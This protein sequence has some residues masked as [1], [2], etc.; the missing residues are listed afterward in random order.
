MQQWDGERRECK[1]ETV[2]IPFQQIAWSNAIYYLYIYF[3][4]SGCKHCFLCIHR[5]YLHTVDGLSNVMHSWFGENAFSIDRK[6]LQNVRNFMQCMRQAPTCLD[7]PDQ[8]FSTVLI[9]PNKIVMKQFPSDSEFLL[10]NFTFFVQFFLPVSI[11]KPKSFCYWNFRISAA[12][13]HTLYMY[14]YR[15]TFSRMFYRGFLCKEY[16]LSRESRVENREDTRVEKKM[17]WIPSL[18]FGSWIS[19]QY[20][21]WNR[22]HY[23]S[24]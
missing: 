2:N 20:F 10:R 16:C 18:N 23:H 11:L 9:N 3:C 21:R 14:C 8:S 1:N 7:R 15:G 12:G 5:L 17:I 19:S 4:T 24:L 13:P 22:C 6:L